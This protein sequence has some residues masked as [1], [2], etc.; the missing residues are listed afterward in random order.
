MF[1]TTG[2]TSRH[3]HHLGTRPTLPCAAQ[4]D[5]GVLSRGIHVAATDH[6][7]WC[8]PCSPLGQS[9][10]RTPLKSSVV[11]ELE[12]SRLEE[13]F[14]LGLWPKALES[15][16]LR[17]SVRDAYKASHVDMKHLAATTCQIK[18]IEHVTQL[19]GHSVHT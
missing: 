7:A 15:L 13:G 5:G 19:I 1:T 17:D 16:R 4:G 6:H 11:M 12:A 9:L 18:Q 10:R 8:G 3:H 2:E 14:L